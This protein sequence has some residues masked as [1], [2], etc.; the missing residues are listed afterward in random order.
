M[1]LHLAI[2]VVHACCVLHNFVRERDGINFENAL[3]ITGLDE[4]EY[5]TNVQAASAIF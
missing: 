5:H 4:F 2:N 1:S 3:T